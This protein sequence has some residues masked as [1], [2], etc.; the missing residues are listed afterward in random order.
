MPPAQGGEREPAAH[1]DPGHPGPG[2]LGH[3]RGVVQGEHV[4]RPVHLADH[5]ADVLE[6]AQA[7]GVQD[8]GTSLLVGLEPG[9]RVG[10]IG[11]AADEVLRPGGEHQA[12]GARVGR[13]GR[14]RDPF[15]RLPDAVDSGLVGEVLD[16]GAGQAD[17]DRQPHG[18]GGPGRIV[19]VGVL[20]V[21]RDRQVRRRHDHRGVDHGLVPAH[22]AVVAAQ[23]G[24]EARARGGQGREAERRE[25]LGRAD[26]PG[27]RHQERLT[28][29]VQIQEPLCFVRLTDHAHNVSPVT[30]DTGTQ[31]VPW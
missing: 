22:R 11:V 15:G 25:Q 5:P 13:L 17:L 8:V 30:P 21:R 7:R 14:R 16:R 12:D 19:R 28:W 10:E 27:V 18:L 29:P 4:D 24:R 23:G 31:F 2:Q 1:R 26:V 20:Q 6:T 9:D 3:G